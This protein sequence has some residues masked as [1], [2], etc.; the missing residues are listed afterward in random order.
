[1]IIKLVPFENKQSLQIGILEE[2]AF[3]LVAFFVPAS[4]L[5]G[6]IASMLASKLTSYGEDFQWR[7]YPV[8]IPEGRALAASF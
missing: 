6:L 4:S 2:I 1:M 8:T 5:T 7:S 3:S